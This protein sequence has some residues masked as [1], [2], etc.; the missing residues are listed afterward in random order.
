MKHISC[1]YVEASWFGQGGLNRYFLVWC[2]AGVIE[3]SQN[4][5]FL[6]F[7]DHTNRDC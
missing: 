7:L 2:K 3:T 5:T 6:K 1:Y 4:K